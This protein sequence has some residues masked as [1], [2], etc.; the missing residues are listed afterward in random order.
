MDKIPCE[1]ITKFSLD[2]TLKY[3]DIYLDT[4]INLYGISYSKLPIDIGPRILKTNLFLITNKIKSY[5]INDYFIKDDTKEIFQILDDHNDTIKLFNIDQ[6][7]KSLYYIGILNHSFKIL[8]STDDD[9][10][11]NNL[12][13]NL[14]DEFIKYN[15]KLEKIDLYIENCFLFSKE[16]QERL[17]NL[18]VW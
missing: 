18:I 16:E 1:I 2:N 5:S 10:N 4:T 3:G 12:S 7:T 14:I 11:M 8:A 15:G 13:K 9:L 17:K 6:Q